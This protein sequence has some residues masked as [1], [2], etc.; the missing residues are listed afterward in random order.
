M[1][2][3]ILPCLSAFALAACG[4]TDSTV[5]DVSAVDHDGMSHAPASGDDG[6]ALTDDGVMPVI[7]VTVAWMRPHPQGRDVTA[8]YFVAGLSDGRVDRLVEAHIDGA[9][10]VELHGHTMDGQG[11][12]RMRPVGPQRIEAGT[13]LEF[14]P[15][16]LH[17]MVHG[18]AAVAEGD[19]ASGV[20]VFERAGAVPVVFSVQASRPADPT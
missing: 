6:A 4:G 9:E 10:R 1:K 19:S 15:G 7:D 13:P 16:G 3:I 8:A 20:L 5:A 17:L 11:V 18:L 14:A 2:T 12:M